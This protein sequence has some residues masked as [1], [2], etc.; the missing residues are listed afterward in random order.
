[1]KSI[2]FNNKFCKN[3]NDKMK[4]AKVKVKVKV[5]AKE[6]PITD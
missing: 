2:F 1:M 5:K 6:S 3:E 4:N